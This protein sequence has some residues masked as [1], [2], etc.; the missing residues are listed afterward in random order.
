M[1]DTI[2]TLLRVTN[3]TE[4]K[5]EGVCPTQSQGS[6]DYE[7]CLASKKYMKWYGDWCCYCRSNCI[8]IEVN[9]INAVNTVSMVV[10]LN[11]G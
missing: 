2:Y 8:N 10:S 3:E 1:I 7:P 5:S 4:V 11:N 6:A 9:A